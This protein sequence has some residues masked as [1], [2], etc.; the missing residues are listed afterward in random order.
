MAHV[1]FLILKP[2]AA[3]R[4]TWQRVTF[5]KLYKINVKKFI[6]NIFLSVSFSNMIY[7]QYSSAASVENEMSRVGEQIFLPRLPNEQRSC[8]SIEITGEIDQG[9]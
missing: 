2:Q 5:P 3:T 8:S 4:T 7:L 1:T 6:L 9:I